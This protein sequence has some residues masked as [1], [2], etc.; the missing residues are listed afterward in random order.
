MEPVASMIKTRS[1]VR[2]GSSQTEAPE[3]DAKALVFWSCVLRCC[4]AAPNM[5]K[6]P[7]DVL[8]PAGILK[9][10]ESGSFV[11]YEAVGRSTRGGAEQPPRWV[12]DGSFTTTVLL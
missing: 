5:P 9:C 8:E 7:P 3:V 6:T 11:V 10:L 12:V 1:M 4:A 2:P